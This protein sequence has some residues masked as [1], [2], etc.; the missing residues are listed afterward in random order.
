M[1]RPPGEPQHRRDLGLAAAGPGDDQVGELVLDGG[2]HGHGLRSCHSGA[3]QVRRGDAGGRQTVRVV[4][5]GVVRRGRSGGQHDL[6]RRGA[7]P[8]P[9]A[10]RRS[11]T[12]SESAST[13]SSSSPVRAGRAPRGGSAGEKPSVSP[14]C[15]ARLSD[16]QLAGRVVSCSAAAS[17]GTSRCGS[18]LVNHEPGPSTTQSASQHRLHGLAGRPAGRRGT[19]A[20][21]DA[22]GRASVA[23]AT[24]PRTVPAR[25]ARPGRSRRT[26]P[27]C[28]AGRPTSAAPGPATPSSRPTQSRP[29]DRVA[30]QLPQRDDQQVADARGRAAR[31]RC[32]T[33]AARPRLQVRPQSSSPHSAASAIRRSPGGSTPSSRRSRPLDPPSSA[34]VTTAVGRSVTRR[35]A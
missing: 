28:P 26:R 18:T 24:C 20:D 5:V 16:E 35:S 9:R 25:P 19:S 2:G 6:A 3:E 23:T 13:T 31:P 10:P 33:G 29:L 17:S 21:A 27:R 7:P 4:L 1:C 12:A 15:G 30:E 11:G 14:G 34:T 32:G 22:P 8:R